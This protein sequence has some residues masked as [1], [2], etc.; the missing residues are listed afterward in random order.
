M[1][2][3]YQPL[4]PPHIVMGWNIFLATGESSS[5]NTDPILQSSRHAHICFSLSLFLHDHFFHYIKA[6]KGIQNL[7]EKREKKLPQ[8][9]YPNMTTVHIW[10]LYVYFH[11]SPFYILMDPLFS[12]DAT[13]TSDLF[14]SY[15]FLKG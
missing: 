12:G 7:M 15:I 11:I 9:H 3:R 13:G 14:L 10:D 8:A 5:D 4:T 1:S 2:Q 6:M